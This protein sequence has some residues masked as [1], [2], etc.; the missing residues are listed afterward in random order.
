[1]ADVLTSVFHH[2]PL[3]GIPALVLTTTE[4]MHI[5][6]ILMERPALL[7][8][9][10][11]TCRLSLLLWLFLLADYTAGYCHDVVMSVCLFLSS[12]MKCIM[13]KQYIIQQKQVNRKC[14]RPGTHFTAFSCLHWPYPFKL[15]PAKFRNFIYYILLCWWRD[16]F[17]YNCC[18]ICLVMRK[19]SNRGDDW[20]VFARH[21]V[22]LLLVLFT[23][24]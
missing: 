11:A 6:W 12:V 23:A 24:W 5:D 18:E 19:Y 7:L 2:R 16:H 10:S 4:S 13:A 17:V 8:H 14:S 9:V 1:M 3:R 20:S 21:L 15:S 22:L